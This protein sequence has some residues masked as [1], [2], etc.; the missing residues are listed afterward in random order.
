MAK[1]LVVVESPAKAKTISKFLGDTYDVRASVGHVADLPSKGL[2]VDVDNGFK[3]TYELTER[4]KQVIKDLKAAL[5]DASELYLAT[6][7][8]REGEAISWHL[9]EY[10]KPKV[11]VKRMVFH[12]ITK[13]AIDHAVAN[14]R[15]IDYGLVDAAETRRI[16]DR[17]YGY[18]VSP[19]L[20]RRVNRGLSAGRVQSP[21]IRL[22]VERERERIAFVSAD[23]WDIGLVTATDPS[24]EATLV[25]V[26][27][28]K[29]ATGRDFDAD[30]RPTDKVV[31]L[32]ED[33]ARRLADGLADADVAVR[34]VEEKPYRSSPKAPF[35][36][37]TLQQDAGR[38]LRLSASQVM[39]VAQGLYE[40]GY[41]TYMRTDNVVLSAEAMGAVRDAIER[42][43]GHS[44]LSPSPKS[45]AGKVKNAQ[46]AHEAIRPTT[47]LRSP[48]QVAGELNSQD[49]ALYRLI[50]QRTLASQMADATGTTV[51]LRLAATSTHESTD[52]E[53]A[54][55]GTTITFPGYRA[56]YE[57]PAA[58]A[59]PTRG[60]G[61]NEPDT[62]DDTA[63]DTET[64][65]RE[66]LLP[67]LAEG[68]LV[69]IASITPEGHST[70]PPARYTEATLV[71][72][73]EELGIGRPSTWAS[74]I[75]T[76]QDR[77]YVWKK[78]TALVP[79]WTAFAVVGLLEQHFDDL[80]DY[81]F[82][83]KIEE[84][85]DAIAAGEGQKDT[86][87][88]RFY[89]GD[90]GELPGLKRLVE[91]NLDEI[92]A[93]AINT[94]PLGLD[95]DGR[96]IVVK[97]GKYGPYV[98]RGDDTA[99]VPDDLPPD[100]L[101]LD[102]AVELLS[103]PKSDEPIGELDGLP[104]FAKNGRYGPYVQWGTPDEP[105]P[106]HDKPKMSSL[107]KTMVL[108]RLTMDEA[109]ALLQLPRTLGEDPSDGEPIVAN[110]GR[111]GPYIVKGKDFRSIDSEEQLLTITLDEALAIL[112]QPK[113]FK[114]GGRSMAAKGPLREFGTDPVSERP[115]VAKD[116][117]FGVYVT[118][119]ETNASIG[120]GDRIEEMLPERAYEL[121]AIRRDKLALE[122]KGPKKKAAPRKKAAAKKRA[123]KKAPAKK[124][125]T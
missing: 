92:D 98:K 103:A 38:R 25:A 14:P 20:W 78:G 122:G 107:F 27:G 8:D 101:T 97:P 74:I 40:R 93:A 73:L 53:F 48:D 36:T 121:L 95:A 41:I 49:L 63:D 18:E 26:D 1:P 61:G 104:V 32:D 109:E 43:Y 87:L 54:A 65:G 13:A 33:R 69:P 90:D 100:E 58:K 86:W 72:R 47:P 3:P 89:F 124:P 85:L 110:N 108:E 9:L 80:V 7:E 88:Q 39:R 79:T 56:V 67:Q 84:D 102:L 119:G 112:A 10:L 94:F 115:V 57:R 123:A 55:S 31:A 116:G 35:M 60:A 4:G 21:S 114:R 105:P 2:A 34:S 120:K 30:G 5:K 6:D 51:S 37:S 70:N 64:A 22:I 118:D 62:G 81:E 106:G 77:G 46:E 125:A 117:K 45:Y 91:E 76:V 71:K 82:T 29:V 52:C 83:A 113:V 75:Q 99:S 44:F 42:G 23:Y 111:Y 50:W 12:E 17:L 96:E 11:P 68:D 66:A 28:T 16:L 24:F 19:V 59:A 15:Q